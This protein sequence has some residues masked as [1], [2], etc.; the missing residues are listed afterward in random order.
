MPELLKGGNGASG[1]AWDTEGLR[2]WYGPGSLDHVN[3]P[4]EHVRHRPV[5][6]VLEVDREPHH[7]TLENRFG[8]LDM[9]GSAHWLPWTRQCPSWT[10]GWPPWT[11]PCPVESTCLGGWG[12]PI[13]EG[14]TDDEIL[15]RIRALEEEVG[16]LRATLCKN[17]EDRY[18]WREQHGRTEDD[19]V[20]ANSS[21]CPCGALLAYDR[22]IPLSEG[23]WDCAAILL[24]KAIPKDEPGSVTHTGKL[25]FAFYEV[26]SWHGAE[27]PSIETILG[28]RG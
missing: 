21:H 2:H 9:G 22:D 15:A 20:V 26:K 12:D 6:Q 19:L 8:D 4:D 1:Q 10:S 18:A 13:Q 27:P 17:R 11:Q 7:L 24:G 14:M 28:A 16:T 23:A 5:A 25:S 3:Q